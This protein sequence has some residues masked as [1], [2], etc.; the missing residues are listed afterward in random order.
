MP[1][2]CLAAAALLATGCAGA[3]ARQAAA[4]ALEAASAD[5]GRIVAYRRC[6]ALGL[7]AIRPEL[8]V[9]ATE[10]GPAAPSTYR[11]LLVAPGTHRLV[12]RGSPVAPVSV[13]VAAGQ[14]AYVEAFVSTGIDLREGGLRLASVEQ[15][16]A[17]AAA[18]APGAAGRRHALTRFRCYPG[19]R[20]APIG[21]ARR[22][23]SAP[24]P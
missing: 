16:R 8:A 24:R 9:N 15:A 12:V 20:K 4:P 10:R 6:D 21:D 19:S 22:G 5:S 17:R 11:V 23:D 18:A 2:H 14:T 3:P 13:D 1:R 7:S